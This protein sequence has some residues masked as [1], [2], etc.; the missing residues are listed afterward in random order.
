MSSTR[1]T[2]NTFFDE[3]AEIIKFLVKSGNYK[4]DTKWFE[5]V[6][7]MPCGCDL[8]PFK[9]YPFQMLKKLFCM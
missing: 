7:W 9:P 8:D 2:A 4:L 3:L 1:D 6:H 5:S